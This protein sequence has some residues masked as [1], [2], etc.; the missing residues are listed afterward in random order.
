MP[1]PARNFLTP[2]QVTQLQQA[3]KESELPHVRERILIILL[4]ND[5]RTQ[6]EIANFLG[7]SLR[8]VAYWCM[9]G[10]PD[11]L[12]T[13]HNKREYEH[14]WKATPEYIELLLK[15]VDKEPS[16]LGYEFGRWTAERLATY[17]S[18]QTGIELSSSQVRRILKQKK[19]SYIW[20]K[21]DLEDKQNPVER[22]KFKE[23][24]VQYLSIAREQPERLQV[25]FW[26]ESGFSLR[27]IRRQN[28]GKKGKRKN[29]PG[30][31]RHGRLNVMG[32]IREADRKRV[33]FFIKKGNADIFYEQLQHLNELIKQ[34]WVNKGNRSEDFSKL[35]SK[36]IL[37][38]DN[39]SFHKRKE[40]LAK[41]SQEFPNF[42]LEFLP[43]YSPDYNMIELVWHSCKEYIA[44]RL[45]KSL[46]E[47]KSLLNK[48]LNQGELVINWHRKIKHKGNNVYIAA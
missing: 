39:A 29:L 16:D 27:V 4:Q 14:Y 45:F 2:E 35:G 48:L 44:H 30:Q 8:T 34:E 10:D 46:D 32:A 38:L 25:W 5:G 12:E 28:W 20:A 37:I 11:N 42:I 43:T 21:Y 9:H 1:P 26:D 41:I 13:L 7:C 18:E 47:L 3:L 15:T 33:C 6:Q 24:L 19:Y 31:R 23:K 40:I 36:I 22:A 17:L